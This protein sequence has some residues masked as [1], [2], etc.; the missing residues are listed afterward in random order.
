MNL[1]RFYSGIKERIPGGRIFNQRRNK[2]GNDEFLRVYR[3]YYNDIYFKGR[4]NVKINNNFLMDD[5]FKFANLSFPMPKTENDFKTLMVEAPDLLFPYRFG[6]DIFDYSIIEKYFDE[7]P[8]EIS[9]NVCL[10]KGD[11]VIDCGANMGLFSNIAL[12]KFCEV[13]AFEPSKSMKMRYLSKYD[14]AALHIEEYALSD[15]TNE[16]IE[17][18][19]DVDQE[20]AS[21]LAG[22]EDKGAGY[23]AFETNTTQKKSENNKISYKVNTITLDDWVE[24]NNIDKIDFIKADIEGSERLMLRG[25]VNVLHDFA[26]K[27]SICTYH[28]KDD[29]IILENIIRQANDNYIIEHRYKKLYAYAPKKS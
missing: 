11:V 19:E 16:E 21:Y 20:G 29:P 23:Y 4:R 14:N 24:K 15:C 28:F 12:A 18:V 25:A 7:G 13:Y 6:N 10:N 1:T 27:I 2:L 9:K 17:F 5:Y 22:I 26:P 8:Y 3:Q